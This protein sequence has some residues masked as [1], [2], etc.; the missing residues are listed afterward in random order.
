MLYTGKDSK[1][2]LNQGKYK[3]KTSNTEINM[4]KIFIAQ[5]VQI[6]LACVGFS[7]GSSFFIKIHRNSAYLFQEIKSEALYALSIFF[8]FW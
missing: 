8:S 5:I 7:I 2:V 3:Y 4:N 1:L 6:V